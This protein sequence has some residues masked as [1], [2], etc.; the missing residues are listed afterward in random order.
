MVSGVAQR[1]RQFER[2]RGLRHTYLPAHG[3]VPLG[4][5]HTSAPSPR[6]DDGLSSAS[7]A[8][9]RPTPSIP[10]IR[11]ACVPS[12]NETVPTT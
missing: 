10:M 9:T 8:A 1:W 7:R 6:E 2:G 4:P 11:I 3:R 5:R 12:R